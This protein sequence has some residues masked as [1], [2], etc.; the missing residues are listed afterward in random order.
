MKILIKLSDL[1]RKYKRNIETQDWI[2]ANFAATN[3]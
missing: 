1:K 3:F 2:S